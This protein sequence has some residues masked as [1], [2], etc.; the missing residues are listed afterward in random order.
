M[1]SSVKKDKILSKASKINSHEG[2]LNVV[3]S[4]RYFA[5]IIFILN[6]SYDKKVGLIAKSRGELMYPSI[7][8]LIGVDFLLIKQILREQNFF[9]KFG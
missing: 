9:A 4:E 5:C 7:Y 6:L 2:G 1:P 3:R 8:K